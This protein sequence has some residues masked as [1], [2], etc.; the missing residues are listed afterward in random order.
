MFELENNRASFFV[1][2]IWKENKSPTL[3]P[4]GKGNTV[5]NFPLHPTSQNTPGAMFCRQV[6]HI[7]F[8][9]FVYSINGIIWGGS[10]HFRASCQGKSCPCQLP[11]PPLCLITLG[12]CYFTGRKLTAKSDRPCTVK[13]VG[14]WGE[15]EGTGNSP[16]LAVTAP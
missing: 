12:S 9:F 10:Q 14:G 16:T 13:G 4:E 7:P 6:F 3:G 8:F 2:V 5:L 15:K 1:I 11:P